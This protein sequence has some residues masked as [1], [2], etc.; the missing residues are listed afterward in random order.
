[1]EKFLQ[2]AEARRGVSALI[3]RVRLQLHQPLGNAKAQAAFLLKG[4]TN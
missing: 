1:M 3:S 2:A 4:K